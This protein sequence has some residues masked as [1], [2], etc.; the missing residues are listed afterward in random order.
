MGQ[1]IRNHNQMETTILIINTQK[2][3]NSADESTSNKQGQLLDISIIAYP[4]YPSGYCHDCNKNG[5][6]EEKEQV[7]ISYQPSLHHF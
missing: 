3:T 1:S 6:Y 4:I 5:V 2:K 7:Q